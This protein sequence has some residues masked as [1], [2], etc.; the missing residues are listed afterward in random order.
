MS[1]C[2]WGGGEGVRESQKERESERERGRERQRQRERRLSV[3]GLGRYKQVKVIQTEL[4]C[5]SVKP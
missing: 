5:S 3:R 2:L 4:S 1:V